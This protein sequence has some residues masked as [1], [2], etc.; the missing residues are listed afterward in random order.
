M[1]PDRVRA[2]VQQH[3]DHEITVIEPIIGGRTDTI[4]AVRFGH[5]DPLILRYAPAAVWGETGRRHIRAEAL[6]QQLM[7]AS[8]LPVPRFVAA[9]PDAR[10]TGD[11]LNLSTWLPGRVRLGTLS[12]PA[13]DELARVAAIIHATAVTVDQRPPPYAFWAPANLQVPT[14]SERPAL[15]EQAIALFGAGPPDTPSGLVHH[16]FHPGNVLWDGDR[17]TGVIDWAETSWGPADLDVVHSVTNIALLQDAASA[18]TFVTAYEQHGGQ[19]DRRSAAR[20]FWVVSDLLGF[21]PDPVPIVRAL[22]R[23]R[24]DLTAV[25]LRHRLEQ[26]LAFTLEPGG[27]SAA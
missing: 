12:A 26:L 7:G 3:C 11:F 17:I 25:V 1:I 22:V 10:H 23:A 24:P 8:G 20:R 9:D 2:W 5:G 27:R 18:Q 16:D 19:V 21:L 4:S 13:I 6:G 14:W 15:W